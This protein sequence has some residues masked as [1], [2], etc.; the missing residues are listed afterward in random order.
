M[1]C[2]VLPALKNTIG[3]RSSM[4]A[5]RWGA[6]ALVEYQ[7]GRVATARGE[8]GVVELGEQE[9]MGTSC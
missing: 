9:L 3:G 8:E 4:L 7:V 5:L 1:E 6:V 2:R